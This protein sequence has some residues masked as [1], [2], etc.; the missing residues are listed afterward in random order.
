[1]INK[2][3]IVKIGDFG[4]AYKE[5]EN[6]EKAGV[7]C[8]TPGYFTPESNNSKYSYK[9]DI[10]DFGVCIYYL[11]G[12]KSL[13]KSSLESAEFFTSKEQLTFERKLNS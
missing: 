5:S 3:N 10:F 12:G 4:F 2:E 6:E 7:I 11:F 8:G 1:M 9:T 13:F